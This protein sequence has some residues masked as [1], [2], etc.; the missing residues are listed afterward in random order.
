MARNTLVYDSQAKFLA[1]RKVGNDWLIN[2]WLGVFDNP[3]AWERRTKQE[4]VLLTTLGKEMISSQ[5]NEDFK[6]REFL[7]EQLKKSDALAKNFISKFGGSDD[8]FI[9]GIIE[10][11]E[12]EKKRQ[13]KDALSRAKEM[14]LLS[15]ERNK[16]K[17]NKLREKLMK[18]SGVRD[19][20]GG[21]EDEKAR[22]GMARF[23]VPSF[24]KG[25]KK[26]VARKSLVQWRMRVD[27][28]VKENFDES[29]LN[30]VRVNHMKKLIDPW[31]L[32]CNGPNLQNRY[33]YQFF[34]FC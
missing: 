23:L 6:R 30:G 19:L 16:E 28:Q 31:V 29:V 4:K 18:S 7:T 12:R 17:K 25:T 22:E 24:D 11:Y 27:S 13:K 14:M 26:V 20:I 10:D 32:I 33:F 9:S 21:L 2:N 15:M 8:N 5:K 1:H 34:R 3:S